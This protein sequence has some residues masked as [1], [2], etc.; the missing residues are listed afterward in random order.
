MTNRPRDARPITTGMGLLNGILVYEYRI[1]RK[2]KNTIQTCNARLT[3]IP[4]GNATDR[5]RR[6]LLALPWW[7]LNR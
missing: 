1:P 2:R 5:T 7:P 3:A 6:R 4:Q